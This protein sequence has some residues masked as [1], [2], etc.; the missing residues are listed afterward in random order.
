MCGMSWFERA[1]NVLSLK[2]VQIPRSCSLPLYKCDDN[3]L[4]MWHWQKLVLQFCVGD[5]IFSVQSMI[6]MTFFLFLFHFGFFFSFSF[7]F[8]PPF[9]SFFLSRVQV[10][11]W[12][13][14]FF[15][16]FFLFFFL[17]VS[18]FSLI[19]FIR[20]VEALKSGYEARYSRG[21]LD[22]VSFQLG[23]RRHSSSGGKQ[24]KTQKQAKQNKL[25]QRQHLKSVKEFVLKWEMTLTQVST[26]VWHS[27][28]QLTFAHHR[29]EHFPCRGTVPLKYI[30]IYIYDFFNSLTWIKDS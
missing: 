25:K 10:F 8:F 28:C 20:R 27:L 4:I 15:F 1:G 22:W 21:R 19:L 14:F 30:Y 16:F 11:L 2:R 26:V 3:S 12:P 29:L 23:N 5:Y 7:S 18:F 17:P 13:G 9:R 24:N 6:H